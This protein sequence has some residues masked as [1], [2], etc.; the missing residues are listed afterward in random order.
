MASPASPA[1]SNQ[2]ST[3]APVATDTSLPFVV[4]LQVGGKLYRLSWI[5]SELTIKPSLTPKP[6][7][8]AEALS[9]AFAIAKKLGELHLA[10]TQVQFGFETEKNKLHEEI[11]LLQTHLNELSKQKDEVSG[12][13]ERISSELSTIAS[14]REELKKRYDGLQQKYEL[15]M[16]KQEEQDKIVQTYKVKLEEAESRVAIAGIGSWVEEARILVLHKLGYTNADRRT[17]SQE[18]YKLSKDKERDKTLQTN[19]DKAISELFGLKSF[20]WTKISRDFY[21]KQRH[22]TVHERPSAEDAVKLVARLPNPFSNDQYKGIFQK[23]I[24]HVAKQVDA[25]EED[26]CA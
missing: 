14:E 6:K 20:E 17:L 24:E 26:V 11:A 23:L 13:C 12:N 16:S 10:F 8:R 5:A 7:T 22:T 3:Q 21:Q 9:L 25:T 15:V 4:D 1:Q 2:L 18:W 19:F